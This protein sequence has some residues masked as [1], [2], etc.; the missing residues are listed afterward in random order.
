MRDGRRRRRSSGLRLGRQKG[1]VLA[2][3]GPA[4]RLIHNQKISDTILTFWQKQES[5]LSSWRSEGV[6]PGN[7]QPKRR[8]GQWSF[9]AQ[10]MPRIY[11]CYP[12][13]SNHRPISGTPCMASKPSAY[14]TG[15]F[16]R[17]GPFPKRIYFGA[18][19]PNECGSGHPHILDRFKLWLELTISCH[20]WTV[21]FWGKHEVFINGNWVW[22][23]FRK[24]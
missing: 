11:Y 3:S 4:A 16:A 8:N 7:D 10:H 19:A 5:L 20:W 1:G 12:Q 22:V 9:P 6:P 14:A 24:G 23:W 13:P 18:T 2:G 15:W 21:S 17:L